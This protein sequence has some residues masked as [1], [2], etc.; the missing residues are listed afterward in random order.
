MVRISGKLKIPNSLAQDAKTAGVIEIH[1]AE[2]AS[3]IQSSQ[4]ASSSCLVC[5]GGTSSRSAADGHLTIDLRTHFREFFYERSNKQVR[6]GGGIPMSELLAE[7][8]G[9][10]RTFPT[11]LSGLP[12]LGYLLTGGISPLSRSLGLAIDQMIEIDGIWGNGQHFRLQQPHAN[13]ASEERL[14]WRGLCGAAPFLAVVTGLKIK[15]FPLKPLRIWRARL[16][17]E[18]LPIAIQHAEGWPRSASFQWIWR[19]QVLAYA[20]IDP[21]DGEAE[22][23]LQ[24]LRNSLPDAVLIAEE[25]IAGLHDLPPFSAPEESKLPSARRHAEVL[26]LL[27]PAWKTAGKEMVQ[28]LRE[29]LRAR[30]DPLCCI[31]SQQLGGMTSIPAPEATSFIHRGAQWKPWITASWP[32]GDLAEREK[33]LHWLKKVWSSMQPLCSGVHLAQLHPHLDWHQQTLKSA[34]GPWL[35]ELKVLKDQLDPQGLLPPL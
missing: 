15:T 33:S 34:F 16:T 7:L 30:P 31:A 12:G 18:Q 27:S 20:V 25:T 10:Q 28:T 3:F 26:S 13:T 11:G 29:L 14:Q 32:A 6:I 23:C 8:L 5:S 24:S 2:L 17:P 4:Q 1:P 9:H 35:T 22:H 19:E 21:A